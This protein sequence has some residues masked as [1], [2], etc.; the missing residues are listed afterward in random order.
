MDCSIQDEAD[1]VG[2]VLRVEGVARR[3]AHVPSDGERN[4]VNL[5]GAAVTAG[6]RRHP[7]KKRH[8]EVRSED[9]LRCSTN[10]TTLTQMSG[11]SE[12]LPASGLLVTAAVYPKYAPCLK[13]VM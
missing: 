6:K 3:F 8:T 1:E 11:G 10:P 4:L 2:E 9:H 7:P 12:N 13:C 5:R